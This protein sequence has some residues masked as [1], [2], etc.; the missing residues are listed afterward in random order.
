MLTRK[1]L[2]YILVLGGKEIMNELIKVGQVLTKNAWHK[3]KAESMTCI[4]VSVEENMFKEMETKYF[5]DNGIRLFAYEL[6]SN[7][8]LWN[9]RNG[10]TISEVR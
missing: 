3:F 1:H 5:F 4:S 10:F 6:M 8:N 7:L 9:T 2:S